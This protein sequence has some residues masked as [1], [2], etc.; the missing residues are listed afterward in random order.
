MSNL[1]V[2][3]FTNNHNNF[4]MFCSIG[5]F[6]TLRWSVLLIKLGVKIFRRSLI[7]DITYFFTD[8]LTC[9]QGCTLLC[10]NNFFI[11]MQ[12]YY[13]VETECLHGRMNSA[14]VLYLKISSWI[15]WNKGTSTFSNYFEQWDYSMRLLINWGSINEPLTFTVLGRSFVQQVL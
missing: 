1:L 6:S 11:V 7:V 15:K 2:S 3:L 8:Y 14:I 10:L 9:H 13:E 5:P 4:D 12:F